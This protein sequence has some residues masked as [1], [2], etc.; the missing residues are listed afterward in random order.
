[1]STYVKTHK[2]SLICCLE[3]IQRV[4]YSHKDGS[5]VEVLKACIGGPKMKFCKTY[6]VST[7]IC[8]CIAIKYYIGKNIKKI[9]R[10]V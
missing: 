3:M 7:L 8:R 2:K 4:L 5:I 9:S 1:M 10:F 6:K